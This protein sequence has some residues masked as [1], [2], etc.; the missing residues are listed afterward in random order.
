MLCDRVAGGAHDHGVHVITKLKVKL[1]ALVPSLFILHPRI[2]MI[3]R[4]CPLTPILDHTV[5]R[6]QTDRQTH[7]HKSYQTS[8]RPHAVVIPVRAGTTHLTVSGCGRN[9]STPAT[10]PILPTTPPLRCCCRRPAR[11]RAINPPKNQFWQRLP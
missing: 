5:L 3:H 9:G 11:R 4:R 2:S 10:K 6:L 8:H 7:T 1:D